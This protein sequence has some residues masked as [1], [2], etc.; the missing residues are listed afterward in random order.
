MSSRRLANGAQLIDFS[1]AEG[2]TR[3]YARAANFSAE[4]IVPAMG[5]VAVESAEEAIVVLPG[6]GEIAAAGWRHRAE[7]PSVAI[8]PPGRFAVAADAAA[9]V[10]LATDRP[11]LDDAAAL[12]AGGVADPRIAPV[13]VPFARRVPLTAPLVLPIDAI[14]VPPDNGR[15]RFVQSATISINIVVYDGPRGRTALSPHEHDAIE[16]GTLAIAGDYVHHLRAPWGRNADAW[17]EDV[18]L[19]APPGS[20]LLIPPRLIHTTEGVGAGAHVMLD[21]FAP[22]RRDFIAKGWMANAADYAAPPA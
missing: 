21:I 9:A 12:N 17:L 19:D 13:G 10:V 7:G 4:W 8:V 1:D 6:G 15:L 20:L 2:G 18:H 16:Q 11:D 5:E 22:P 14:P 3:R